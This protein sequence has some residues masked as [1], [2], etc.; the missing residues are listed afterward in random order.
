ML[1]PISNR[2]MAFVVVV[3]FDV[4]P[5]L[6]RGSRSPGTRTALASLFP[7]RISACCRPRR[8]DLDRQVRA[9]RERHR[10]NRTQ[11]ESEHLSTSTS[12]VQ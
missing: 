11:P 4:S 2:V 7:L 8:V 1:Y 5:A 10:R 6:P 9:A 12:R 3:L